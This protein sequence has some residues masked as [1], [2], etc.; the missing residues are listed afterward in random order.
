MAKKEVIG[1]IKLQVPAGG[2]NPSPPVG[3]ALGQ[4]GLNIMDFCKKFNDETK[5]FE[6]GMPIPVIITAYA[7]RSFDFVTKTPPVSFLIM[8]HLKIKKGSGTTGKE[9]IKEVKQSDFK[10]IAE[11]KQK[12]LDLPLESIIS[13]VAGTAKSMGIKVLED[14]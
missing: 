9:V 4:K 7:D 2:A 13:M 1:I 5:E 12:D 6:K 8:K 11:V 3:P 14:N 10:S